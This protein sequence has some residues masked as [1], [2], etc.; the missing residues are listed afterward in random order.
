MYVC[1]PL[2]CLVRKKPEDTE[3]PRIRFIVVSHHVGIKPRYSGG[4]ARA[5][6]HQSHLSSPKI[7]F[8]NQK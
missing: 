6:N 7:L 2:V 4:T 1:E 3:S 8:L 5:L